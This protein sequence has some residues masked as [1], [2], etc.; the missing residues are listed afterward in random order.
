MGRYVT[1]LLPPLAQPVPRV[2]GRVCVSERASA[3]A[4]V[5][6]PF[7]GLHNGNC[8][9]PPA[10][11]GTKPFAAA[12]ESA[13]G[14][15]CHPAGQAGPPSCQARVEQSWRSAAGAPPRLPRGREP[16]RGVS[17]R[18]ALP[19]RVGYTSQLLQVT[20]QP[21]LK[22]LGTSPRLP[23]LQLRFPQAAV[24]KLFKSLRPLCV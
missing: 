2:R 12:H 8:A 18:T 22:Q 20:W 17:E 23:E 10:P 1:L 15:S 11:A 3:R 13:G 21:V 14:C 5:T 9:A 24:S 7:S 16:G 4:R 19:K 6:Q